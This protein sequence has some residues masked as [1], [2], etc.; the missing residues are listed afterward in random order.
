M[1]SRDCLL[2]LLSISVYILVFVL[3]FLVVVSVRQIMLTHVGFR[4]S[5]KIAS[6]IVSYRIVSRYP[7]IAI[8]SHHRLL[9]LGQGRGQKDPK[10]KEPRTGVGFL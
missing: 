9:I 8:V 5:V 1:D 4:A 10:P 2:L 7:T 6:S 3:H